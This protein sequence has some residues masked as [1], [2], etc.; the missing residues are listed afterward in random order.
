MVIDDKLCIDLFSRN[1]RPY[2]GNKSFFLEKNPD[3]LKYLKER[4]PDSDSLQETM[5]RIINH[6]EKRPVCKSCGGRL[7]FNID[8]KQFPSFCSAYCSNNDEN[9]KALIKKTKK[10]LYG[11]ENYNNFEKNKQTCF[12]RYGVTSF[13]KTNEFI[14][15]VKKSNQ[16]KFG[17]DWA[18]Q[19]ETVKKKG[20]ITKLRKYSD[21]N[22]NNREKAEKTSI[23]R[24]GVK[25]TKQS[26]QAKEKEKIT[27]LK[28]YGVTSYSKTE[29][30]KQ[31]HINTYLKHFGVT[32]NTKSEE[33][34]RKWYGNQEWVKN[35]NENIYKTMKENNSFNHSRPESIIYYILKEKYNKII[36]QYK[37][38]ERYPYKCDFYIPDIDVF[39]EYDGY[40]THGGH[41]FDQNNEDDIKRLNI[42]KSK[43]NKLYE[44]AIRVWTIDDPEKRR[45][46][47]KNNLKYIVLHYEDYKTPE[48]IFEK[49]DGTLTRK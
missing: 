15:R 17:K 8:K 12:E 7:K 46:A 40:W 32:H 2:F 14:D 45:V 21:E 33:W 4:Y 27:C 34:K 6:I 1:G 26:D 29:E 18:L 25:N 23:E 35:R 38:D 49:I 30:S 24:Y 41:D 48:V 10:E 5:Y 37:D 42:W 43:E 22:F 11:D 20:K 39:I 31:K 9:K 47:K 16:K 36:R 44:T 13:T 19:D 3:I 28:K